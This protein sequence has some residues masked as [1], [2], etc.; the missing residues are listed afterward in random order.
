MFELKIIPYARSIF[1]RYAEMHI[2][3]ENAIN[4]CMIWF[5]NM[6]V[7]HYNVHSLTDYRIPYFILFFS[8]KLMK[9]P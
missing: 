1:D 6:R 8:S 5:D 7:N 9:L 3:L 4:L 2:N